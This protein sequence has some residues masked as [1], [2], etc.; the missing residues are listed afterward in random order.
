M[1]QYKAVVQFKTQQKKISMEKEF[2]FSF[3]AK[4]FA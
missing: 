4:N 3:L 2:T 1:H